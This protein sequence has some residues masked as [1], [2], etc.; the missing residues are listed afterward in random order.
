MEQSDIIVA[1]AGFLLLTITFFGLLLRELKIALPKTSFTIEKQKNIFNRTFFSL[2]GWFVIV[3][4]LSLS[5]VIQDFTS[6]P[7]KFFIV[8]IIPLITI[9][10]ITFSNALKEILNVIPQQNII[11]L[12]VFR[13]FVEILLWLLFIK[14]VLPVQM[15]FEGRNFDVVSGL[16]AP[17]VAYLSA[18]K[19]ASKT[20]LIIWNILCLAILIN[21][22]AIAILSTPTPFRVFMNEPANT[23]VAYFPVVLLPAFLVPL[24][25]GLHFFSLKHL[26][27][28]DN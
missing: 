8:I 6:L 9:V 1:Q 22:V 11:R 23:I 3:S 5:G 14:N 17:A 2:I 15:T 24:A 12:Q 28:K 4:A 16:T 27:Q 25:Y 26:L 20:I 13:V 19:Y 18:S 21:I 7:P 10:I